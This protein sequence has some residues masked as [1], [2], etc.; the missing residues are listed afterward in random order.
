MFSC[1]EA[2]HEASVW[3]SRWQWLNT[4]CISV[5]RSICALTALLAY[6]NLRF[7][8]SLT[9]L[10]S[11]ELFETLWSIMLSLN[12][13]WPEWSVEGTI[14]LT[15]SFTG[16]K[17]WMPNNFPWWLHLNTRDCMFFLPIL[18]ILFGFC[19]IVFIYCRK[20]SL[21][22][23]DWCACCVG[24]C[25]WKA[26][27]WSSLGRIPLI[28]ATKR[29]SQGAIPCF[30]IFFPCKV[31]KCMLRVLIDSLFFALAFQVSKPLLRRT[32]DGR[33]LNWSTEEDDSL[34]TLQEV[35]ERVSP[36]L[37]FNIELKFD[38]NIIYHRKDLECAL[39]AILQV[40][41]FSLLHIELSTISSD[42][43]TF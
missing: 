15:T 7:S 17:R 24:G 12:I 11:H 13:Q 3:I 21:F 36:R 39:Q 38:D 26:G 33:V 35:F 42:L 34:C 28:W 9:W 19:T 16:H 40:Q 18:F 10:I 27:Y 22:E 20:N 30:I 29:I 37:G 4:R 8:V 25:I 23:T 41:L 5:D 43:R 2:L 32:G 31:H 1:A 14:E 6:S